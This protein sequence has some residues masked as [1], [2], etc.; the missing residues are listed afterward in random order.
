MDTD[1]KRWD[2]IVNQNKDNNETD[3]LDYELG[4]DE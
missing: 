4:D 3:K 2:K 1:T